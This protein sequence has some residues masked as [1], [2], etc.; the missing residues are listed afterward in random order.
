M[1]TDHQ[2]LRVFRIIAANQLQEHGVLLLTHQQVTTDQVLRTLLQVVGEPVQDSI[3][4]ASPQAVVQGHPQVILQDHQV[5]AAGLPAQV[6]AHQA[7]LHHQ[8]GVAG[9]K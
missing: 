4:A 2:D 9:N 1:R 8:A 3:I 6:Q 5:V 7:R